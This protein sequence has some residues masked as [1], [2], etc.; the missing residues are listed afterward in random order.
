ML[1][2]QADRYPSVAE[3]KWRMYKCFNFLSAY[4]EALETVTRLYI[5]SILCVFILKL[6]EKLR[7]IRLMHLCLRIK[8][9]NGHFVC[10]YVQADL[11]KWFLVQAKISH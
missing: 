6:K 10:F 8:V 1:S 5:Y 9:G 7:I 11:K 2:L 4:Q 3:V